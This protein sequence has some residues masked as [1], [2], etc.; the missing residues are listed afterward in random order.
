MSAI[1]VFKYLDASTMHIT[2]HDSELLTIAAKQK[3]GNSCCGHIIVFDYDE[4]FF[5]PVT[6]LDGDDHENFGELSA[7]FMR[8][9]EKARASGCYILRLDCDGTEHDD[10]DKHNW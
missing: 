9:Y 1:G 2:K 10:L 4:G 5:I 7:S 8:L 3:F 6:D